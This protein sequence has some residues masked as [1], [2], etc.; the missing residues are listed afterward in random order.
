MA[1]MP[2]ER[3]QRVIDSVWERTVEA[4]QELEAQ[5]ARS[6]H[7]GPSDPDWAA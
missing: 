7:R 2:A 6:C 5:A 4:R 3:L 1:Q